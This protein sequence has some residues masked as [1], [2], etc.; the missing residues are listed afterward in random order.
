M[1]KNYCMKRYKKIS[2]MNMISYKLNICDIY[3]NDN[4]YVYKMVL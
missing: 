1:E 4:L 2:S 3:K